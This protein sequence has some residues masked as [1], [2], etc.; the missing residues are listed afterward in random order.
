MKIVPEKVSVIANVEA[1]Q[2][3]VI[4]EGFRMTLSK[5]E[6]EVLRDG[7]TQGLR[8]L[9]LVQPDAGGSSGRRF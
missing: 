3:T 8:Q 9:D 4:M 1:A 6:C 2:L 7:L 5:G